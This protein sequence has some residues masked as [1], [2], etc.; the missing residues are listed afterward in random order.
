MLRILGRGATIGLPLAAIGTYASV[1]VNLMFVAVL[2][3][4]S[5]FS[6]VGCPPVIAERQ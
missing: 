2:L 6:D 1:L 3:L 5:H 4:L